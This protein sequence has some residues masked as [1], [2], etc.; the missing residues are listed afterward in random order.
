MPF[1]SEAQ[2]RWMYANHPD[3]AKKWEDHTPKGKKLPEH[4]AKHED[5]MRPIADFN[6]V[7][8]IC[9]QCMTRHNDSGR[10]MQCIKK[11]VSAAHD[12]LK[13]NDNPSIGKHITRDP[14]SRWKTHP[15]REEIEED[16]MA[17]NTFVEKLDE[18][19]GL[20]EGKKNWIK[21]ATKNKGGLHKSLGVPEGEKIPKKAINV[22]AKEGGKVGKQGRLAKTLGKFGK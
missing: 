8:G 21:D 4:V 9:P 15:K 19:F 5:I 2:R 6:I 11:N 12:L 16:K 13:T 10:C 3:M 1:K 14:A 7:E 22:A 20:G 17:D 18:I